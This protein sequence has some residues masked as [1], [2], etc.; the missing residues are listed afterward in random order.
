MAD[1]YGGVDGHLRAQNAVPRTQK[2]KAIEEYEKEVENAK[3][4]YRGSRSQTERTR[5]EFDIQGAQAA[6]GKA[7]KWEEY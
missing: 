4:R 1:N 2:K 3:K 7:R 6:L 5:A